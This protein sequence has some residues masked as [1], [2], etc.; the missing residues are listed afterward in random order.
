MNLA[1][2]PLFP[3]SASEHADR[4]DLLFAGLVIVSIGVMLVLA[5]LITFCVIRYRVG[6]R[7]D[8][9]PIRTSV[10][11]MEISW[12]LVTTLIFLGFFVWGASLYLERPAPR[13]N[14]NKIYVVARQWMWDIRYPNGTRGHNRVYVALGQP[15]E[16]I[17]TS[18]D[19]IHSFFV[20][21]LRVKQ[22]VLPGRY[23]TLSFTP[24][25]VGTYPFYCAEYCGTKHSAMLGQLVIQ[26]PE[27]HASWAKDGAT[28]KPLADE[29][30][31]LFA[32]AGCAG[33]HMPGAAVHAPSLENLFGKSVPL[34]DGN[35]VKADAQ[36]IHD[37][38]L[39]PL[40]Q[41][42]AGFA[43]VMP[44]YQGQLNEAQVLALVE[45]IKTLGDAENSRDRPNPEMLKK[46]I[47]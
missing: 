26:T 34:S 15:V 23:T 3:V 46:E 7:A 41:V 8:R 13:P 35:F 40:K 37:S 38:I 19:V 29:G 4:V 32:T 11:R 25:R 10:I 47:K 30:R 18:E 27:G 36:Y 31:A 24:N 9:S 21:A 14:V 2:L 22:D 42:A 17:M 43:P 16:L 33:C 39:L 12:S 44:S 6:S 28:I 45:Y 20:P 5:A 1:T